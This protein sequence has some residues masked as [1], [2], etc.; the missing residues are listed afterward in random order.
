MLLV[1]GFDPAGGERGGVFGWDGRDL[2][3]LDTRSTTGLRN[4]AGVL[5]QCGWM[6]G[7]DHSELRVSDTRGTVTQAHLDDVGNPHDVISVGGLVAVVATAQNQVAWF[8][9]DGDRIRTWQAQGEPDSWHLNSLVLH[10]SR[11]LACAFGRFRRRKE[12]DML[13]RPASGC[14]F[15]VE[16]GSTIL[17][18]LRAPHTP[19]FHAGSWLVCNS[20]DQA[21]VQC[22]ADGRRQVLA[23][24][25]GWPRGL[26]ITPDA[27][28]IGVSPPRHAVYNA[29]VSSSVVLLDPVSWQVI[30][31]FA[32]PVREIYDLELVPVGLA[33]GLAAGRRAVLHLSGR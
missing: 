26:V 8:R 27:V 9:S 17:G 21:L 4:A 11:L 12:W 10:R 23:T 29:G 33:R 32:V 1:S 25:P 14:L 24:F 18:G 3:C 6:A 13:G 28:F 20:A 2:T 15:D 30:T 5:L 16:S 31:E 19:R 22:S 7:S